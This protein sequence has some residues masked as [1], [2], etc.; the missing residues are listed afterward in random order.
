[1]QPS[2]EVSRQNPARRQ[3]RHILVTCTTAHYQTPTDVSRKATVCTLSNQLGMPHTRYR[4][5]LSRAIARL[6]ECQHPNMLQGINLAQSIY[7]WKVNTWRCPRLCHMRLDLSG[8]RMSPGCLER[9]SPATS[10]QQPANTMGASFADTP[11]R[12]RSHTPASPVQHVR[13]VIPEE[14][15]SKKC[16]KDSILLLS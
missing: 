2:S 15:R 14:S 1:M 16:R 11:A 12:P 9:W 7:R 13:K 4:S 3:S 6:E 8:E 10:R 5:S